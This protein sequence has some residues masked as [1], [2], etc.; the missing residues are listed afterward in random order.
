MGAEAKQLGIHQLFGT[1]KLTQ[2]AVEE[3]GEGA[4]HFADK[5]SLILALKQELNADTTVLVKGSRGMRM[6]DI[7][8]ALTTDC[9]ELSSC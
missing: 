9:Q 1:G 5:A 4:L 2:N 7:V 8:I 6:E 3:F